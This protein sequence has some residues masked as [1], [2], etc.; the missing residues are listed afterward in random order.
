[1]QTSITICFTV[2]DSTF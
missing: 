2:P 1:V